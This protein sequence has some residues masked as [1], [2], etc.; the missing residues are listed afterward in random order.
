MFG[1]ASI[2]SFVATLNSVLGGNGTASFTDGVLS[3]SASG[4]NGLVI[5]DDASNPTSRAG[6][7]FSQF[8]GLNDLF[9]SA[10][11]MIPTTGLQ[12]SD[13]GGFVPGGTISLLLKGPAGQRVGETTVSVTG[14]T[15]GDMVAALNSAFT[16]KQ[17]SRSMPMDKCR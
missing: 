4:G 2:G 7:A 17:H 6:V 9:V 5:S 3:L 15:I 12:S 16:G 11:N 13:I 1:T 8:F 10:G 14:T